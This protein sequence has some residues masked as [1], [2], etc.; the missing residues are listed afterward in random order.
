YQDDDLLQ[1]YQD[2]ALLLK[3]LGYGTEH[4]IAALF[5]NILKE[6]DA[7]PNE[8]LRY[9]NMEVMDALRLME[10]SEN[11]EKI[12][13]LL[14]VK[15]NEIAFPVKMAEQLYNL[16]NSED[17][18]EKEIRDML[19]ETEDYYLKCAVG[20]MFYDPLFIAFVE[21]RKRSGVY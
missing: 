5:M 14:L 8:V 9:C 7:I 16:M 6:T 19:H 15:K 11:C 1:K 18:S 17:R 21:C 10:E 12:K 3:E 4:F 2:I 20:T 13:K